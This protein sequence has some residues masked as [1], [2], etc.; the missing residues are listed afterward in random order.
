MK[1]HQENRG[2]CIA[3]AML[4]ALMTLASCSGSTDQVQ[5]QTPKGE[6]GAE[7]QAK[8]PSY[9]EPIPKRVLERSAERWR[10]IVEAAAKEERWVE[11]Y[12]FLTPAVRKE[13]PI[14]A[15]LPS[16]AKFDY[17]QP[18]KPKLLKL[19]GDR[20]YVAVNATWLAYTNPDVRAAEGGANLIKP[21]QSIEEWEWVEGE[22]YLHQPHRASDFHKEHPDFFA[23]KDDSSDGETEE[24]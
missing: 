22:W 16:K 12:G 23:R 4:S 8:S 13:Y 11:I 24:D 1:Q 6:A 3:A 14:T 18:T 17:D 15:Y 20:A 9:G 21:F 19:E 7:A 5:A 2:L 10:L